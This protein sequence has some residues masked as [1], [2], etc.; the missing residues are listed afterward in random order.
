M[1]VFRKEGKIIKLTPLIVRLTDA[2]LSELKKRS[3][4]LKM[5][6]AALIRLYL[7]EALAIK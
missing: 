7:N 2:Q 1:G 4:S 6:R 5:K 3:K